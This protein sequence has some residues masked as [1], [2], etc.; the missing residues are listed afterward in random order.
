[1]TPPAAQLRSALRQRGFR[2]FAEIV[3]AVE[4]D[5]RRGWLAL[6]SAHIQAVAGSEPDDDLWRQLHDWLV[7]KGV[8][9]VDIPGPSGVPARAGRSRRR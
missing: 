7:G 9:I 1:M 3:E 6:D 4:R 8:R 5:P 2:Q